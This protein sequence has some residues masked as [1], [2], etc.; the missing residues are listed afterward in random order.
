MNISIFTDRKPEIRKHVIEMS[1]QGDMIYLR[2]HEKKITLAIDGVMNKVYLS[3]MFRYGNKHA[4]ATQSKYIPE[5]NES[6]YVGNLM[7][8]PTV[9]EMRNKFYS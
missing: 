3:L 6:K 1:A 8:S 5:I 4:I 9:T 2:T 7:H